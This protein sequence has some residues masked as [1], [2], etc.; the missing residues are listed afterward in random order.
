VLRARRE[1]RIPKRTSKVS[2]F[3]MCS[4]LLSSVFPVILT[5]VLSVDEEGGRMV[6]DIVD[7]FRERSVEANPMP[8]LPS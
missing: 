8:P 1:Y 7:K 5:V 6:C 3:G 2:S 4:V